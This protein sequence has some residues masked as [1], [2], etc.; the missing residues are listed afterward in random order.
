MNVYVCVDGFMHVDTHVWG[1][2]VYGMQMC[3]GTCICMCVDVCV[4]MWCAEVCRHMHVHVCGEAVTQHSLLVK[5]MVSASVAAVTHD[6]KCPL[7]PSGSGSAG[8]RPGLDPGWRWGFL[9]ILGTS[10]R[11]PVSSC[12]QAEEDTC[13]RRLGPPGVSRPPTP[14]ATAQPTELRGFVCDTSDCTFPFLVY[15]SLHQE[16][17]APGGAVG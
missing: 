2:C 13:S 6:H 17:G 3:L 9:E 8:S 14:A 10:R 5:A 1:M 11:C 7:R 15:V 16:D 12:P 4:C